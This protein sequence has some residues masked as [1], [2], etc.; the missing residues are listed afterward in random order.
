MVTSPLPKSSALLEADFS[1]YLREDRHL[2]EST[3]ET[4][5]KNLRRLRRRVNIWDVDS[6]K[7]FI[8][9][10][11]WANNYKAILEFTYYDFCLF[12]GFD[13]KPTKYP[14]EQKIPYVP[15]EKDIDELIVGFKYSKYMPLIQ[16]LKESG[17]RPEEAFRLTPDDFDLD[18]IVVTL[19]SARALSICGG[20]P[21]MRRRS[22]VRI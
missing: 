16:L 12:N 4:K 10:S 11:S 17:F 20:P 13:Y 3:V 15:L 7:R 1:K 14:R 6:V 19:N 22:T 18:S 9:G 21:T 2:S 5:V 8:A